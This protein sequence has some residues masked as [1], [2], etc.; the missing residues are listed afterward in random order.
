MTDEEADEAL[1]EKFEKYGR[2]A[3]QMMLEEFQKMI[4]LQL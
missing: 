4:L 3:I 2:D 1:K